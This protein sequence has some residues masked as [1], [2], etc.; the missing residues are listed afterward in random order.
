MKPSNR[1]SIKQL[2][3]GEIAMELNVN[4][5]RSFQMLYSWEQVKTR[6]KE[7]IEKI[8]E[9]RDKCSSAKSTEKC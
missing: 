8:I 5:L 3:T 7:E 2:R 9:V 4:G 6:L 1:I